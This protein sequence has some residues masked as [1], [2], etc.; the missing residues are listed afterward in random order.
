LHSGIGVACGPLLL[1]L[2]LLFG[3]VYQQG[4]YG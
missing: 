3:H 1:L 2:L 4:N